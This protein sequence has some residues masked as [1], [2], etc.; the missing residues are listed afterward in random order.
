MSRIEKLINKL[1]SRPI[2]FTW[3]EL[4][5]L[6]RFYGYEEIKTGKTSGSRKAF[7][8]DSS[9]HVIRLHKPHPGNILKKYQIDRIIDELKKEELL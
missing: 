5:K 3:D 1:L 4:G 9:N 2:D 7:I 8:K 6:L